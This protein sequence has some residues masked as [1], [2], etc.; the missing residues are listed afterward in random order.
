MIYEKSIVYPNKISENIGGFGC[1]GVIPS[2][3]NQGIAKNLVFLGENK[4][5]LD[6]VDGAFLGYTYL[7]DYYKKLGYQPDKYYWMG[8]KRLL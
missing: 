4:L 2:Y 8:E 1:I 7:E 5:L 3:R 6:N